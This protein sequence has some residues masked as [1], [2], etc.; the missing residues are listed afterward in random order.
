MSHTHYT[1]KPMSVRNKKADLK[2]ESKSC[3]NINRLSYYLRLVRIDQKGRRGLISIRLDQWG[4][5]QLIASAEATLGWSM[6]PCLCVW[7][8]GSNVR[9]ELVGTSWDDKSPEAIINWTASSKPS[10]KPL[11]PSDSE[12]C[13]DSGLP[14]SHQ[15]ALHV[16]RWVPGTLFNLARASKLQQQ[17][18]SRQYWA[19]VRQRCQGTPTKT[20]LDGGSKSQSEHLKWSG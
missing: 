9:Q 11:R 15:A 8:R 4:W 14:E 17:E 12:D 6:W 19:K 5:R 18:W 1:A 13:R 10:S 3:V 7:F 20:V 2:S 16:R